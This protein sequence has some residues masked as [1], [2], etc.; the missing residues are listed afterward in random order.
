MISVRKTKAAVGTS[1]TPSSADATSKAEAP[2]PAPGASAEPVIKPAYPPPAA[3]PTQTGPQGIRYDFNQ[4]ARVRLRDLDT[5][6]ILFESENQGAF[7]ASSK[8]F[9]VRFRLEVFEGE[10]LVFEHDHDCKDREVLVQFPIGTLGD[11]LA[12]FPYAARFGEVRGAKL[13]CAMSGL[14][15]PLLKDAYPQIAFVTHE[16]MVERKAWNSSMRDWAEKPGDQV[17]GGIEGE[18][19]GTSPLACL[20]ADEL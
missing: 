6:N 10:T 11:T 4:G 2:S 12:W 18:R 15:I 19:S 8:K 16:E 3:S 7:V 17:E 20:F 9:Y 1:A 5:G 14:I 13:T